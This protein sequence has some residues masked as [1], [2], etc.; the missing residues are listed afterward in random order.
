[1]LFC[2]GGFDAVISF[3]DLPISFVDPIWEESTIKFLSEVMDTFKQLHT[4]WYLVSLIV[5]NHAMLEQN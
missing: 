4:L 2:F 5:S 3:K 1:M